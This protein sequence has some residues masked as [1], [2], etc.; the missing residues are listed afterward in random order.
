MSQISNFSIAELTASKLAK[1]HKID[2]TPDQVALYN[3][4]NNLMPNLEKI[5]SLLGDK[6]I[7]ITS[8]FRS[9][10]LNEKVGGS[11]TSAH[12]HGL[13]ADFVC[14][15]FGEPSRVVS[16]IRKHFSDIGFD[17]LIDEGTWVHVGFCNSKPRGQVL[18][19]TGGKYVEI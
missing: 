19:F 10:E 1:S 2:N 18:K 13:A 7:K 17:Q 4:Y 14:P 9:K 3:I 11:K 5:R 8:G 12:M 6:E 16:E 15:D